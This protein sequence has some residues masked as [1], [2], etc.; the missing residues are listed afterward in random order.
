MG[1]AIRSWH[2]TGDH[3]DLLEL[4]GE[5]DE[6]IELFAEFWEYM[7]IHAIESCRNS[8]EMIQGTN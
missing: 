1:T 2:S 8:S 3:V 5:F 6:E 7:K 4:Q